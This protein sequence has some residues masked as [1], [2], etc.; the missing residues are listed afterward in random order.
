[1]GKR[2]IASIGVAAKRGVTYHGLAINVDLDLGPFDWIHPCGLKNVTMTSLAL[3]REIPVTNTL[4]TNTLV[5]RHLVSHLGQALN[6][7]WILANDTQTA[8]A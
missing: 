1:V 4:V 7:E 3:E 8:M 6:R 2:K 5:R